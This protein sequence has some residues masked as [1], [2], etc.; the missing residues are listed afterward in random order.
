MLRR[1]VVPFAVL[2]QTHMA[3]Y[4]GTVNH[5]D[6][7]GGFWQLRTSSGESYQLRGGDG[8][9]RVEGQAVVIEGKVDTGAMGIGMSGPILDV[10]SW[11]KA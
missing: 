10:A 3:S 11:K 5:N 9:L 2:N 8:S 7:E 6:L 4:S 1:G